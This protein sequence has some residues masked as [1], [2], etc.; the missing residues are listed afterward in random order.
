MSRLLKNKFDCN[1]LSA[2]NGLEALSLLEDEEVDIIFLDVTMP[3][4]DGVETLRVIRKNDGLKE[5]PVIILSSVADKDTIDELNKLKIHSYMLKP[6]TY[7]TAYKAIK[8]IFDKILSERKIANSFETLIES[9]IDGRKK[10]VIVD[11]D[12]YFNEEFRLKLSEKF[13]I[14]DSDSG[15][16]G[17][18]IILKE[19]PDFIFLAENLKMLDGIFIA[20]KIKNLIEQE[21]T[22]QDFSFNYSRF[23]TKIYLMKSIKDDNDYET[24]LLQITDNEKN[25]F[26]DVFIKTNEPGIL[27]KG[28][29]KALKF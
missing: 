3:I 28:L 29:S 5:I 4:M 23:N 7:E 8:K 9:E 18:N 2:E 26:D 6:L 27:L 10:I 15:P 13:I 19:K 1:V 25:L 16:K 12:E 14:F 17:L 22:A 20:N 24:T 21:E 11:P